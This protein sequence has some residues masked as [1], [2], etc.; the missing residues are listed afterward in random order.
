MEDETT[1]NATKQQLII[2]IKFLD[3]DADGVFFPCVEYLDLVCPLSG[4]AEDI[5]VSI[6]LQ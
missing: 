6:F 5:T 2:Y 3:I 4:Q 1:D